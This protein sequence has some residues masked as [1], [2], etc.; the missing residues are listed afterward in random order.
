M[1]TMT[2]QSYNAEKRAGCT[3]M[4][5]A[6]GEPLPIWLAVLIATPCQAR[7]EDGGHAV[8]WTTVAGRAM[9]TNFGRVPERIEP[10]GVQLCGGETLAVSWMPGETA[11]TLEVLS[12]A[13]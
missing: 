2:G 13:A 1:R 8:R 3:V 9:Y 7:G 12:Q 11:Y 10:L 5:K 6:N 4:P